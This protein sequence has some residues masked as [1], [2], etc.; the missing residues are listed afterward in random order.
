M[1]EFA[2]AHSRSVAP[3]HNERLRPLQLM[4]RFCVGKDHV[5]D[6][7]LLAALDQG[8]DVGDPL[9]DAW[10]AHAQTLP[11]Q[12]MDLYQ[13]ALQH[14]IDS[15]VDAP[16]ALVDLFVDLEREPDWLDW[17]QVDRGAVTL[18]R[19]PILQ[20]LMLQSVS[21]MG[22]YAVPGLAQPLLETG[23]LAYSVLPRMARTLMFAGAVTSRYAMQK[24]QPGYLQAGHVRLVH[25]LVRHRLTHSPDWDFEQFGV[26]I[27][28]TDLVATNLQFSLVVLYGLRAFGS[29]LSPDERESVLHLWRYIGHVMGL[30]SDAMPASE[31]ACSEW[32]YAYLATQRMDCERARPLAQALHE[33]PL[34]LAGARKLDQRAA[35]L[36]QQV[37]AGVTRWFMGQRL[38]DG[39]GLPDPRWVSPVL[40]GTGGS[41]FV[42]DRLRD[43]PPLGHWLTQSA[44]GYREHVKGK[45]MRAEPSLAP[46]FMALEQAIAALTGAQEGRAT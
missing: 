17:A 19:Y 26:P 15:V 45:Y 27:N 35:R 8:Y 7:A 34:L 16:Q 2:F 31:Q 24:H 3:Q 11:R 39:L 36:E 43:V 21:L 23:S 37:R 1:T 20:S 12:G 14:G 32:L 42:L 33:L 10:V 6:R 4:R 29:H 28:Q 38:A 30:D 13:R 40:L 25:T 22:G 41:Q 18:A 46:A 9:C 44:L 5:P